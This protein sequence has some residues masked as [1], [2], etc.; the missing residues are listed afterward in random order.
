M[1]SQ[2]IEWIDVSKGIAIILMVLGHTT[3]PKPISNFIWAFHMPLF[4]IASGLCTK[5]GGGGYI[6]FIKK[7][8]ISLLIPFIIYSIVVLP[9][10][11][12]I[13]TTTFN[14]WLLTGWQG[15]ALWFIPVLYFSLLISKLVINIVT[16]HI[17]G[18]LAFI[19][20][21]LV[22]GVVLCHYNIGHNWTLSS[23][24]YATFLILLGAYFKKWI[25]K[26]N[27]PKWYYVI[28]SLI[29]TIV[30]SQIWRLDMAWNHIMPIIPIT[31]GACSG[32]YLVFSISSYICKYC[33]TIKA[34]LS[35]IGMETYIILAFS[36]IIIMLMIHYTGWPSLVRYLVMIVT[37][38]VIKYLKDLV[39]RIVGSKIL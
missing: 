2:R 39:N 30:V 35:A 24:P 10:A 20:S 23:I 1:H 28:A 3:I 15:I 16:V 12:S 18:G 22:V 31:I 14:K 13:G 21:L 29:V 5:W 4:F 33:K 26:I 32:T 17:F 8:T 7:K 9:I 37:L 38:I 36:Q 11:I 34:I 25:H 19:V 27:E 6:N